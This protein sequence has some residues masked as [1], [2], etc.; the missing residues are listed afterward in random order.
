V[1][2]AGVAAGDTRVERR[3]ALRALLLGGGA[4]LAALAAGP[5]AAG[6]DG[7]LAAGDDAAVLTTLAVLEDTAVYVYDTAGPSLTR[8]PLPGYAQ[9]FLTHHRA[10]RDLLVRTIRGLRATPPATARAHPDAVP[11][12]PGE[13]PAVAAMLEIEGRLL[14]AQYAALAALG[15]Q[16]LRVQVASIFGVDARHA[17]V[18]RSAGG[19]NPVPAS[20][21]TGP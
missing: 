19:Q 17:A 6:V 10:H 9:S 5:F 16:P 14:G 12:A 18:W 11:T 15:A 20:F 13:A 4:A 8:L 1:S 7:V 21:V 2:T 3:A